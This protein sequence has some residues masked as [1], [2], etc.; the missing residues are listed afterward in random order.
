MKKK[1]LLS[2]VCLVLMA[3]TSFAQTTWLQDLN[4]FDKIVLEGDVSG[5]DVSKSNDN[6]SIL[7]EGAKNENV[8]ASIQ[9]G[10][11][12]LTLKDADNALVHVFNSDLKRIEGASDLEVSGAEFIGSKGKYLITDSND[13]NRHTFI[14]S[15]G[16][17]FDFNFNHDFDIALDIDLDELEDLDLNVRVDIDDRDWDWNWQ[18]EWNWEDH[19]DEF[20]SHSKAFK[21][22]LKESLQHIK[23]DLKDDLKEFKRD[24][25]RLD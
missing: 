19:R 18:W 5:I 8:S 22:E 11:L 21:S 4:R 10:T 13:H 16:H 7:I 6:I 1:Q 20:R 2:V 25:K 15:G 9:A 17:D 23:E 14:H 3:T 24:L 12:Y